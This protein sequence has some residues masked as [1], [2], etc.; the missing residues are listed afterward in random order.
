MHSWHNIFTT[1]NYPEASIIQGLLEE[2]SI[3]V[4]MLNKMDSSYQTFGEIELFVPI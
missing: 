1:N 4:Q 3:P 2:N